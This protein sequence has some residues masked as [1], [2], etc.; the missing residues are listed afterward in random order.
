M[1]MVDLLVNGWTISGIVSLLVM[2]LAKILPEEK[3]VKSI[4]PMVYK[5]GVFVSKFLILRIGKRAAEK[6]ETGIIKTLLVVV[7]SIIKS[8]LE[9]MISDNETKK[10]K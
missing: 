6:F 1:D 5:A 8:F 9:G 4:A 7:I 10:P 3:V 2:V